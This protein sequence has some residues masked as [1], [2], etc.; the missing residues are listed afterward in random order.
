MDVGGSMDDHIQQVEELFSAAKHEF[1][2]MEFFYFHNCLYESVWKDNKRRHDRIPTYDIFN[3]YNNDY[4]VIIVGDASMATYE[5]SHEGGSVEHF[6][7]EAGS[8]WLQRLKDNYPHL[9][10]LNPIPPAYWKYTRSI[11]I[12]KDF[13]N[14]K[15][16]PVTIPGLTAAMQCLKDGKMSGPE[17]YSSPEERFFNIS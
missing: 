14:D 11:E 2:H 13:F 4:R 3:K 6:N 16:F 7:E 12:L 5:I 10:W 8:V 9:I 15:M 1:K 17:N